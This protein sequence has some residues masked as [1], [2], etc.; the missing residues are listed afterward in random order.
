M[1]LGLEWK[2]TP[3]IADRWS[4]WCGAETEQAAR[5]AG[6]VRVQLNTTGSWTEPINNRSCIFADIKVEAYR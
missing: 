5:I 2:E 4:V 3:A 1:A 6:R